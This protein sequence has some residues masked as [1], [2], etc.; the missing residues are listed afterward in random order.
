MLNFDKFLTLKTEVKYQLYT[1]ALEQILNFINHL[2][3]LSTN[4]QLPKPSTELLKLDNCINSEAQ[5]ENN[6]SKINVHQEHAQHSKIS[7]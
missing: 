6:S 1:D 4:L 2:I 3:T 7:K 5:N